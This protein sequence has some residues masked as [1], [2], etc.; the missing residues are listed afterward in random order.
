MAL[1]VMELFAKLFLDTSEYESG[2]SKAGALAKNGLGT[3]AK[4]GGAAITAST[5]A[6]TAFGKSSV[7]AGMSFDSSMSQVAATMGTT[8][9]EISELRD[10]AKEMGSTTAFSATQ[11]ADA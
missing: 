2:L 4:V 7:D 9:D 11:A 3:I 6:I 1:N 5:A 10:F 8:V